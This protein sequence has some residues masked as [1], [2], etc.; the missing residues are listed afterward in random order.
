MALF[1]GRWDKCSGFTR[2]EGGG[3]VLNQISRGRRSAASRRIDGVN[4]NRR[5]QPVFENANE[6]MLIALALDS[7]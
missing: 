1:L 3:D 2:P 5:K 6:H 4:V 7:P